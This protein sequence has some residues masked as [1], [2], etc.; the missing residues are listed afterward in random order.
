MADRYFQTCL[1]IF[2]HSEDS[3]MSERV[4]TN[5]LLQG[6]TRAADNDDKN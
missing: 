1:R 4:L 5:R 3:E 6:T 2:I